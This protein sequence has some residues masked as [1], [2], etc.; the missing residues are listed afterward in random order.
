[1][2]YQPT[3]IY[4]Y[5]PYKLYPQDKLPSLTVGGIQLKLNISFTNT[6]LNVFLVQCRSK[7][8]I[9]LVSAGFKLI[10]A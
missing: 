5:T 8:G 7:L 1:M 10:F 2:F 3:P 4:E 6:C 9:F